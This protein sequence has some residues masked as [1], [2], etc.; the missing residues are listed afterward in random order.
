MNSKV[1]SFFEWIPV[2]KKVLAEI[3]EQI[4]GYMKKHGFK[5]KIPDMPATNPPPDASHIVPTAPMA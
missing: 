2:A 1:T 3:P 4:T 5:P